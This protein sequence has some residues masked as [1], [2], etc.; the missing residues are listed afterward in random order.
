M[1]TDA[2]RKQKIK[3]LEARM[4]QIN[5]LAG[6]LKADSLNPKFLLIEKAVLARKAQLKKAAAARIASKKL[7]KSF[8]AKKSRS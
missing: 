4:A 6:K 3:E 2:E 8:K 1:A 7:L 5:S